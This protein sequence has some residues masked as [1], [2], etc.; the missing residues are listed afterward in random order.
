MWA[1]VLSLVIPQHKGPPWFTKALAIKIWADR[2][3]TALAWLSYPL[4]ACLPRFLLCLPPAHCSPFDFLHTP[5]YFLCDG[6]WLLFLPPRTILILYLFDIPK[7]KRPFLNHW[8]SWE[9]GTHEARALWHSPSSRS[10]NVGV[11]ECGSVEA[12]L[13]TTAPASLG[14][15]ADARKLA[16]WRVLLR[17]TLQN[18]GANSKVNN[19]PCCFP[20]FLFLS[21]SI[22]LHIAV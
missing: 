20:T 6:L 18:K 7:Y 10:Q 4:P 5:K 21:N 22:F 9:R 8:D 15:T 11:S 14:S 3:G 1:C 17:I 12:H 16:L 2:Q 19:T 13:A